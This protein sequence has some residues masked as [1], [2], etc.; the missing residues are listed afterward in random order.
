MNDRQRSLTSC[1]GAIVVIC[2]QVLGC[3]ACGHAAQSATAQQPTIDQI[4]ELWRQRQDA[5]TSA[6]FVWSS[7]RTIF[8]GTSFDEDGQP[9]PSSDVTNVRDGCRLVY[10]DGKF[11]YRYHPVSM[12]SQKGRSREATDAITFDGEK[13]LSYTPAGLLEYDE[14]YYDA[15]DFTE[16]GNYNIWALLLNFRLFDASSLGMLP[17]ALELRDDIDAVNDTECVVVDWVQERGRRE[18]VVNKLPPHEI[19][20]FRDYRLS[21]GGTGD[22]IEYLRAQLDITYPPDH[23]Q[24]MT[25]PDGWV[26]TF[27]SPE[28][29][30]RRAKC[31]VTGFSLNQEVAESEFTLKPFPVG[32]LIVDERDGSKYWQ[33]EGGKLEPVAT[34]LRP[35]PPAENGL[36]SASLG[37]WTYW[38]G[39]TLAL[40]LIMVL[41][42]LVRARRIG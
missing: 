28:G 33:R 38:I 26:L 37:R 10:D 22:P 34:S 15:R 2:V 7:T 5:V 35:A 8:A 11:A 32:T 18:L 13:Y 41:L 20:S 40:A 4:I 42:A 31:Q 24:E 16:M 29:P 1:L 19:L 9:T 14:A 36:P 39:G 17:A 25:V 6:V 3:T 27:F 30:Q 12:S 23:H 21:K